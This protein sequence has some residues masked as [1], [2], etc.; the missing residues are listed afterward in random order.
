MFP[1]TP[2]ET[3]LALKDLDRAVDAARVD[4]DL[5]AGPWVGAVVCVA[6]LLLL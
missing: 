6:V 1:M 5:R 3:A 2:L 4:K